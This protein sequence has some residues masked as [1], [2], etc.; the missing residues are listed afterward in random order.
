MAGRLH[1]TARREYRTKVRFI[2]AHETIVVITQMSEAQRVL[3]C[4]LVD[5][6]HPLPR[7]SCLG[8]GRSLPRCGAFD[9]SSPQARLAKQFSVGGV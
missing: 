8:G 5:Q 3:R 2:E 6:R 1:P 9:V 7:A 4:G